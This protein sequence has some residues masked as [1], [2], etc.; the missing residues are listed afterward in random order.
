MPTHEPVIECSLAF[1][2][3]AGNTMSVEDV[4]ALSCAS[5]AWREAV[6]VRH[7]GVVNFCDPVRIHRL[8]EPRRFLRYG[9]NRDERKQEASVPKHRHC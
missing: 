2:T 6:T 1:L 8:T 9:G 3:M 7:D 5:R 4:A